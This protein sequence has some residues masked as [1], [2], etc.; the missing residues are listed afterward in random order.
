VRLESLVAANLTLEQETAAFE[1][2]KPRLAE[3]WARV[4]PNDD[5]PYTVVVVPSLTTEP[6][7]LARHAGALFLEETLL[8]FLI[9]LRNGARG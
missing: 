3:L 6:G 8:F 9:R 7:E 4:F 5:E 1:R 2:L